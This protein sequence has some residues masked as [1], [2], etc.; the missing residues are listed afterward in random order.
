MSYPQLEL[1]V[2]IL[3]YGLI[4]LFAL[5]LVWHFRPLRVRRLCSAGQAG[6]L[7]FVQD[8]HLHIAF[9]GLL[10]VYAIFVPGLVALYF[11]P[12]GGSIMF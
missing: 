12:N 10:M 8:L 5:S 7:R 11:G 2:R 3:G 9:A 6:S 4:T 1:A